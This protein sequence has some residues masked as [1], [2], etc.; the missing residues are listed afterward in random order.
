MENRRRVVV[1]GMGGL[2]PIGGTVRQMWESAREGV[3]GIDFIRSFD[4]SAHKVQT[5]LHVL[6]RLAARLK[7]GKR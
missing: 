5:R 2:S 6:E 3:C 1:T 7:P 4:A